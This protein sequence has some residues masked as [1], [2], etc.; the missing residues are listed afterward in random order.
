MKTCITVYIS[1]QTFGSK[2]APGEK[3]MNIIIT[4]CLVIKLLVV[5]FY[6]FWFLR[7]KDVKTLEKEASINKYG[8][9][10]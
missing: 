7:S 6:S 5:P 4:M 3:A 10:Y 1:I 8:S 2:E 9:L